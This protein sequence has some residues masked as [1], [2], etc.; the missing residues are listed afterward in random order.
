MLKRDNTFIFTFSAIFLFTLNFLSQ[1]IDSFHTRKCL[2]LCSFSSH[3]S[4]N[5]FFLLLS[6][7]ADMMFL[8]NWLP[9]LFF[10]EY[11]FLLWKS[12]TKGF[13]ILES[14]KQSQCHWKHLILQD[15][16][17]P[18]NSNEIGLCQVIYYRTN[19]YCYVQYLVMV[20]Q[21]G[22]ELFSMFFLSGSA[23]NSKSINVTIKVDILNI[24]FNSKLKLWSSFLT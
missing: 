24:S 22:I 20:T 21:K 18:A 19:S 16:V 17:Q 23:G 6:C 8:F 9:W 7:K 15:A 11:G 1:H 13:C 4:K 10:I 2:S 12:C 14:L 3:F 5:M